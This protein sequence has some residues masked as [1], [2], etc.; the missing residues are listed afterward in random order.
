VKIKARPINIKNWFKVLLVILYIAYCI[1]GGIFLIIAPWFPFW[2][3]NIFLYHFPILRYIFNNFY[4]RGAISG[5]GLVLLGIGVKE[6]NLF[7]KKMS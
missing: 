4:I 7:F 1:D 6:L 2:Q 3:Q 5:I